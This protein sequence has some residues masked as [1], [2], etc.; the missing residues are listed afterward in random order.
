MEPSLTTLDLAALAPFQLKPFYSPRIWGFDDLAPWF[1]RR[2]GPGETPIGEAWLSGPQSLIA[3]GPLKGKNLAQ[4]VK[5]YPQVIV[6]ERFAAE[7]EYPLLVK[8]L[9][10]KEKLS[11]QVHPD[12][13]LAR[14]KGEPRGKTECWYVLE[15]KPDAKIALGLH[16]GV[17]ADQVRAAIVDETMEKLLGWV[18]VST[19]D[20]VYVDAGTVHAIWP[21]VVIMET[22]Q[23]SDTTYRLYDYGRPRELH[24]D[25]SLEAMRTATRAGKIA[26]T[27]GTRGEAV[28]VDERYFRVERWEGDAAGMSMA[29]REEGGTQLLFVANGTLRM[30][31]PNF[32]AFQLGRCELAVIPASAERWEAR[33]EAEV[34]RIVPQGGAPGA[35]GG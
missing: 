19:G 31:G 1:D 26:R 21:G 28:L 13:E 20:M 6:G 7:A 29:A 25:A 24:V 9:F 5:E 16:P 17:T 32:E 8:V 2:V 23:T 3:N 18:P 22:Q 14:S 15:A 33:G 10:P 27:Q 34:M 35:A 11:V 4:A 30:E 12:D